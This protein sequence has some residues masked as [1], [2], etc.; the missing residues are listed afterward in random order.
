MH[1]S[2][3]FGN[4]DVP[5]GTGTPMR[6]RQVRNATR[7]EGQVLVLFALMIVAMLAFA[8]LA[9]DVSGAYVAE[10][11]QK[12]VTDAVSLAGAQD[13]F[14]PTSRAVNSTQQQTALK[15]AMKD[16]A[17]ELN[18]VPVPSCP[19]VSFGSGTGAGWKIVDCSLGTGQYHAW[20]T[21][22]S[23]SCVSCDP[24]RSVQ[25]TLGRP[26]FDV[27]FGRL[28]GQKTWNIAATS[29]SGTAPGI[30]YGLVVLRP[31]TP[32]RGC[33][34]STDILNDVEVKGD[35]TTLTI[36]NGDIGSNTSVYSNSST[37]GALVVLNTGFHIYH[38]CPQEVWNG[39]ADG[40]TIQPPPLNDP[41][42]VTSDQFNAMF[43][44]LQTNSL[45]ANQD[46]G[47]VT[48][49]PPSSAT[50]N[51]PAGA[52][53]YLPGYYPSGAC[54]G[55]GQCAFTVQS[56]ETVYLLPGVY[57]FGGNVNINGTLIGGNVSGQPGVALLFK[58]DDGA[59]HPYVFQGPSGSSSSLGISLNMGDSICAQDSCRATPVGVLTFPLLETQTH[60]PIT[61]VVEKYPGCFEPGTT[62]PTACTDT[63]NDN[64][65]KLINLSG[66]SQLDVA[67]IIY[68]PTDQLQLKGKTGAHST[69][70]QV[71]AWKITYTG[72][73][74][75]D[76]SFPGLFY[77][78]VVRIDAACSK[79]SPATPCN[80]P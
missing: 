50:V 41:N 18:V 75:Y 56:S 44:Y 43:A 40:V 27:T 17:I 54:T 20:L 8:S 26:S 59:G 48:P 38:L 66:G 74:S 71:V 46:A 57:A 67:G 36:R 51:P 1:V 64:Q 35:N 28:F 79:G 68:A 3:H 37:G 52:T 11:F 76:Q 34:T 12:T 61:I 45:F 55:G 80:S 24:R 62:T 19:Q 7:Q 2:E 72:G 42:Y 31:Q 63:N 6:H 21:T 15:N 30:R 14:D 69:L 13:L 65:N 60:V 58:K 78:G 5:D 33:T 16:L 22:P 10:R 29:V 25:V 4:N 9:I 49:C 77:S 32:R 47:K 53:C 70:G 73:T 23:P 39:G